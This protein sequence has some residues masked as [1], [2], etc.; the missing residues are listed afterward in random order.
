M[1]ALRIIAGVL[2]FVLLLIILVIVAWRIERQQ[3]VTVMANKCKLDRLR[4]SFAAWPCSTCIKLLEIESPD[5]KK[6]CPDCWHSFSTRV[7][8]FTNKATADA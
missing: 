4:D 8:A 1:R 5:S 7:A 3:K 2:G 6:R